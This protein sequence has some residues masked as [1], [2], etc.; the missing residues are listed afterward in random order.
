MK[1][2][3]LLF[4]MG[5]AINSAFSQ[6]LLTEN[7]AYTST[8]TA[9]K[10]TLTNPAIGGSVWKRHSGTGTPIVWSPTG[11]TY[12]GYAGSGVGGSVSFTNG[13]GSREDANV[14]LSDSIKSGSV[15]FSFLV[16]VTA[17]GGTTGDYNVH[18]SSTVGT[19]GV[20]IFAGRIFIKDGAT[21]G[22]FK[23]GLSKSSAAA[24]A[25]FTTADYNY[26]TTYLVV[27][28]YTFNSAANDDVVS[29]YILS[30]GVPA[31]EPAT[32]DLTATDMTVSDLPKILGVCIRQG[33]VGT[34]AAIL[35]GFR[36]G[37]SW[38]S[39][40]LPIKL[41]S[42]NATGLK[43]VVN[44]NWSAICSENSCNFIVERSI[45]GVNFLEISNTNATSEGNY[46][47]ADRN[48]PNAST[49]Y[50]RLK[51][52]NANGKVEYSTV[53]KVQTKDIK[54][55][56]SPNPTSNEILVNA[57]SNIAAVNVFD[58]TGK[59][60]YSVQN[61][62]TNSIRISVANLPEGTYVVKSTTIDGETVSN[63]IV[64][65]H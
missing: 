2:I 60:I 12:A 33:T 21:A 36:V 47:S 35:D 42:F 57:T 20:T 53:Q 13:T 14:A 5:F 9:A 15:Y 45:D 30:S 56:V 34:A 18:L 65:K 26:N 37:T 62:N 32:A 4:V 23:L 25:V 63:K 11:L 43:N 64:V 46:Y 55:S 54:L 19:A 8:G 27:V 16:N 41:N 39:A 38:F 51:I 17:S 49:L 28:K 59:S 44:L 22:T 6:V 48:L 7:F 3:V 31:T 24:A 29:A 40:P 1:K 52:V 50:Y 10:D 61:N 58:L